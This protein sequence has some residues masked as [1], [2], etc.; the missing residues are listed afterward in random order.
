MKYLSKYMPLHK[1][2]LLHKL[3]SLVALT[4]SLSSCGGKDSHVSSAPWKETDKHLTCDQLLLEMNDAKFWQGVAQRNK[5]FGV[6]DVIFPI[7]YMNTKSSAD[8]AMAATSSRLTNLNNIYQIK[9]CAKP[10]AD[11]PIPAPSV[12]P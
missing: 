9:G 10:Y 5:E 2:S 12:Q 4:M 8:D 11:T 1:S 3:T 6:S 7:A